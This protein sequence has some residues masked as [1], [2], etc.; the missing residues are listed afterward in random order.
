MTDERLWRAY[1]K[2]RYRLRSALGLIRELHAVTVMGLWF[3]TD[4]GAWGTRNALGQMDLKLEFEVRCSW[5]GEMG[6]FEDPMAALRAGLRHS[7]YVDRGL[8]HRT[9]LHAASGA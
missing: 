9:R 8:F 6:V 3:G 2:A 1:G 5:C 7:P 4:G